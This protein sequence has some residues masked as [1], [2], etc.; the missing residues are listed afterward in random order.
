MVSVERNDKRLDEEGRPIRFVTM[1]KNK[2]GEDGRS[3]RFV[4]RQI[5]LGVDKKGKKVTSA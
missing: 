4:L 1:S 2:D 5:E 3:F